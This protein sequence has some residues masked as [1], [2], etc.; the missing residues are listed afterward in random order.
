MDDV[1]PLHSSDED[2]NA[3]VVEDSEVE[4]SD[5]DDAPSAHPGV[6]A[7][8]QNLHSSGLLSLLN[9]ST[10]P[11]V[12]AAQ[13]DPGC[14]LLDGAPCRGST[15]Q[16]D[17]ALSCA[18]SVSMLRQLC[19][20][21]PEVTAT[22][23][24]KA[25]HVEDFV[26]SLCSCSVRWQHASP[27]LTL[28]Y[29]ASAPPLLVVCAHCGKICVSRCTPRVSMG[30]GSGF[31][32][33]SAVTLCAGAVAFRPCRHFMRERAAGAQVGQNDIRSA[34]RHRMS[35]WHS[36]RTI[37]A[38]EWLI[39]GCVTYEI[40][41]DCLGSLSSPVAVGIGC[42]TPSCKVNIDTAWAPGTRG[43]ADCWG[44]CIEEN[45]SDDDVDSLHES[46][47]LGSARAVFGGQFDDDGVPGVWDLGDELNLRTGDVLLVTL[48]AGRAW[49]DV[50]GGDHVDRELTLQVWRNDTRAY[51]KCLRGLCGTAEIEEPLAL[52]VALKYANDGV[53]VRRMSLPG[54]RA[55][56]IE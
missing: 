40:T 29:S 23:A 50:N 10:A 56:I 16:Q 1:A 15:L 11:D 39:R 24:E 33:L 38:N 42:V 32:N 41:L 35:G 48:D 19:D 7:L 21:P 37:V 25:L 4:G 12:P 26:A 18:R 44:F 13:A 14:A 55:R 51:A 5:D 52:A 27:T 2:E 36:F 9:S 34:V 8:L 31:H 6:L 30:D 47:A 54:D 45:P 3:E 22:M 17:I 53:H 43:W 46:R 28:T 49:R 20:L